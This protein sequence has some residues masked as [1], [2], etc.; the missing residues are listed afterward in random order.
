MDFSAKWKG[1]LEASFL[2][3]GFSMTPNPSSQ[4]QEF[5]ALLVHRGFLDR[6]EA[7]EVLKSASKEGFEAALLKLTGWGEKKV[8][9]LLR[10]RGLA[11]PDI[12]GYRFEKKLGSGGTSEVFGVRR[13]KDFRKVALKILRPTLARDVYAIKRFLEEGK[14]LGKLNI[15]GIVRGYR[16]F[17]FMGTYVLE[18]DWIP[19]QTLEDLLAEGKTFPET[20]ALDIV[21]KVGKLLELMR[22]EGVLHRDLKPGNIMIASGERVSLIDLGFAGE[23]MSGRSDKDSTLGTPAYLAPEQAR[24]EDSLDARADI[25]SL[26]ATLYHLVLGK[27]PFSGSNDQEMMRAQILKSL[28]GSALKGREVSPSLHYFLE[29]MMAKDREIRYPSAS[30]LISHIES[31]RK[32]QND[33]A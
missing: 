1:F 7:M 4:N 23:G 22:K 9:Y 14:L 25:Y 2:K 30:A 32:A 29:K 10:T 24:G 19:G 5:L 16:T 20:E 12:P 13:A 31:H 28:D 11:E 18:M 26:G 17:K 6:Q 21:V 15:P 33:L 8:A 27:L 3:L